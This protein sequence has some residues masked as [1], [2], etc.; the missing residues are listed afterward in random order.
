[1]NNPAQGTSPASIGV[2]KNFALYRFYDRNETLLYVGITGNPRGRLRGHLR[3]QSWAK[4]IARATFE[5]FDTREK[6][7][8]AE[9]SA[10]QTEHPLH[11]V[12][13]QLK[14]PKPSKIP[15]MRRSL[16]QEDRQ[17]RQELHRRLA[18]RHEQEKIKL[19][20]QEHEKREALVLRLAGSIDPHEVE[21]RVYAQYLLD[22]PIPTELDFVCSFCKA[23]VDEPCRKRSYVGKG[24]YHAKRMDRRWSAER[25]IKHDASRTASRAWKK[26]KSELKYVHPSDRPG[27]RTRSR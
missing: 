5:H 14:P 1:M 15:R 20:H 13:H 3:S 27:A 9:R 4:E 24:V 25:K 11:N 26:A 8:D 12:Q 18:E 22:H 10:I 2:Q 19:Q 6:V 23:S 21:E 16:P 7:K 17:E